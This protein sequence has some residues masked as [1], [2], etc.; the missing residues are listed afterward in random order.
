MAKI[1]KVNWPVEMVTKE[2]KKPKVLFTQHIDGISSLGKEIKIS[3]KAHVSKNKSGFKIEY[4][5]PTISICVGIGNDHTCEL[6]MDVEAW[7][8]LNDGEK[9]HVATTKE[10]I[11]KYVIKN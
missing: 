8:A 3:P 7:K 5:V 2:G 9:L 10:F 4:A 6:T 1:K 11:N